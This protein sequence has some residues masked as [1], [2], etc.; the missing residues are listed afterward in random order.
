VQAGYLVAAVATTVGLLV[1]SGERQD[2]LVAELRTQA[3]VDSLT[4]LVTRRVLD[5][6]ASSALSGA[7]SEQGTGLI[8]LDIDHF[9]RINDEHG[10]LAGDEVL[11]QVSKVLMDTS[12]ASDTVSRM[13]GDEIAVLLAGCSVEGLRRRAEQILLDM[14]AGDFT[15]DTGVPL[16]ITVSIGI[17]HLPTHGSNLRALYGAADTSLYVAK[18]C[19]RDQVGPMPDAVLPV[20][21]A[22]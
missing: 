19:G 22:A 21:S 4:G 15:A 10:H 17:A 8:L 16:S 5:E 20:S 1:L 2:V 14:R 6:A 11:V 13:G 12:R 7:A 18:R 9:K 3:A